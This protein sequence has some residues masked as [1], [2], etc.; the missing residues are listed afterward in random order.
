ML[1]SKAFLVFMWVLITHHL[2]FWIDLVLAVIKPLI[3]SSFYF[4]VSLIKMRVF[5]INTEA[6]LTVFFDFPKSKPK[7]QK[8]HCQDSQLTES[9]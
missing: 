8:R 2:S 4:R 1:Y 6:K 5:K 3:L 9:E 7:W